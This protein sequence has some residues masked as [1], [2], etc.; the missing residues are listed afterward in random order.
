MFFDKYKDKKHMDIIITS[1]IALFIVIVISFITMKLIDN[2]SMWFEEI[3]KLYSIVAPFVYALIIAYILNPIMKFFEKRFH[4]KRKISVLC[5]YLLI[6]SILSVLSIYLMPKIVNNIVDFIR[7]I[8]YFAEEAQKW[9]NNILSNSKVQDIIN[10]SF[11]TFDPNIVI[12][13]VSEISVN[14]LNSLVTNMVSITGSLIKWVFGFLISIY[15]LFDKEKFV[16]GAKK[17]TLRVVRPKYGKL[18]IGIVRNLNRMVGTYVGIKAVDSSIIAL[19]VFIGLTIIKAPYAILIAAVVGVTNMIPYFG[20]FIGMV[21]GFV[22]NVFFSPM[23]AVICVIFLF[24]LQQFD[25]WYLD[26]KLIGDKVG[27]S[28]FAVIFAVTF[29]GGIYGAIGMVL[30]VP[31]MAV[32]KIYMDKYFW[33]KRNKKVKYKKINKKNNNAS[34]KRSDAIN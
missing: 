19:I 24:L 10:S 23:K 11:Q 4:F 6:I 17:V 5:T 12:N 13:K 8:P 26:P 22:I 30:A 1:S 33:I 28:P 34:T 14:L 27:L 15:I 2:Y 32:I 3:S 9:V 16:Y 21:V 7:N 20:P 18:I 31:I 29:G 25:A